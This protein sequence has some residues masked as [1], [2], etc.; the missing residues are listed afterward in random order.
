MLPY[1]IRVLAKAVY[2]VASDR[3][4]TADTPAKM[5]GVANF[6][7]TTYLCPA[8][9]HPE[10]FGLCSACSKPTANMKKNL[11]RIATTLTAFGSLKQF[12]MAKQP[13]LADIAAKIKAR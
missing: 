2:K 5:A 6:I 13:W 10:A 11:L 7:F 4:S 1:G 3:F 9:I 8:I 12:D